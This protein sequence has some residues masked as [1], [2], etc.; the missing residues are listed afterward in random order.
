M[1]LREFSTIALLGAHTCGECH[2]QN[3]GFVGPWTHDK[4]GFDNSF[5]T[6]LLKEEWVANPNVEQLQFMDRE[7]KQLM[8]LP[9]DM[10]LMVDPAYLKIAKMYAEDND[11]WCKDFAAAFEKLTKVGT[12]NL[13]KVSADSK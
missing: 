7:T 5:F 9:A 4:Y 12:N 10:A 8:M 13:R 3:S 2:L 11:L 1:A 6:H